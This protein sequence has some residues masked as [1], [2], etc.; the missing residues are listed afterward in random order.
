[1]ILG[2]GLDVVETQRIARAL[3]LHGGRFEERVYT[4]AE[5]AACADRA[6]RAQALA[7]RFAAKEA[8]LKALGTGSARGISFQQVEVVRVDGGSAAMSLTGSA[9]AE[10]RR[11]GV[12]HIHLSLSH[13]PGLAAAVVILE[14]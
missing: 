2:V 8:L 14:S 9:A 6:D 1:M 13:Q 12:R 11:K 10:A 7:R 3:A 5:L 4:A